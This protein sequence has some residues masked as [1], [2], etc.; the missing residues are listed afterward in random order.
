M[1]S[2]PIARPKDEGRRSIEE[3]ASRRIQIERSLKHTRDGLLDWLRVEYSVEKPTTRLKDG[4]SLDCD[5]LVEE[6]RK[7]RGKRNP[8]S[9][10]AL[11]SL[12]EE[13]A[14]TVVPAQSLGAEAVGLERRISDLVNEAYGL[15]PADVELMWQTAPPR[16]PITVSE[17]G[18]RSGG[19]VDDIGG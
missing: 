5:E 6:V 19:R 13:H 18:R 1:E 7:V 8:L 17:S 3:A 2:L 14:R 11:R 12:R 16:M 10:A 9:V 15:G 4:L